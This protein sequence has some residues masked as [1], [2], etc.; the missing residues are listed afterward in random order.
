M[1]LQ[2]WD[3]CTIKSRTVEMRNCNQCTVLF[4]EIDVR[5]LELDVVTMSKIHF[6]DSPTVI[7]NTH[8]YLST[9][10]REVEVARV[11]NIA[12]SSEGSGAGGLAVETLTVQAFKLIKDDAETWESDKYYHATFDRDGILSCSDLPSLARDQMIDLSPKTPRWLGSSSSSSN[13]NDNNNTCTG[14][15]CRRSQR[16]GQIDSRLLCVSLLWVPTVGASCSLAE[17]EKAITIA[18]KGAERLSC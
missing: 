15:S 8:I 11:R 10:C 6:A 14:H 12:Q 2:L 5:R 7:E 13:D 1:I 17:E 4:D 16:R 9:T 3:S 18:C